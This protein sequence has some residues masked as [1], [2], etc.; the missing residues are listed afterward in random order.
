[1]NDGTNLNS[2]TVSIIKKKNE[3]NVTPFPLFVSFYCFYIVV[4]NKNSYKDWKL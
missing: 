2:K 4:S 3:K 1:M